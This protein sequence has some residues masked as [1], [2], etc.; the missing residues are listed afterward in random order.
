MLYR[1]T[2]YRKEK[3]KAAHILSLQHHG[4]K[5]IF[6][7]P[8]RQDLEHTHAHAHAHAHTLHYPN[9]LPILKGEK[10]KAVHPASAAAA[11][12]VL[13]AQNN[14]TSRISN[15]S[16]LH[17]S[18]PLLSSPPPPQTLLAPSNLSILPSNPLL[19]SL[20]PTLSPSPTIPPFSSSLSLLAH[21]GVK[22]ASC[23]S[24]PSRIRSTT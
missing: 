24:G 18:P 17:N 14:Q 22:I 3:A 8:D 9:L 21:N 19:I 4:E 6:S 11:Y 10:F 20:T 12:P 13:N 2:L 1:C 15:I 23:P 5:T 16:Y 7:H